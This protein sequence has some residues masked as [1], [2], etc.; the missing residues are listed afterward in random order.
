V[1]AR[2]W[3]VVFMSAWATAAEPAP[4]VGVEV[5]LVRASRG[6]PYV[7]PA[8]RDELVDLQ[9]LPYN[10][11]ERVGGGTVRVAV[12]GTQDLNLGLGVQVRATVSGIGASSAPVLV[13]VMRDGQALT[14]TTLERPFERAGVISAGRDGAAVL[15]VPVTV[16]R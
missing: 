11:F 15:I 9:S 16:H 10:R 5:Q 6:E 14:R 12:G 1:F 2:A 4:T 13:Q 3:W 7:D 8:L